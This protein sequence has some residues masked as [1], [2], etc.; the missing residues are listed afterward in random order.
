M[1]FLKTA[2]AKVTHPSISGA[3]WGQ[4]RRKAGDQSF[5]TRIAKVVSSEY[6]PDKYLLSH[7]TIVASVDVQDGPGALGRSLVGG[8]EI[9][10]KY[11][12]YLVTPETAQFVNNNGDCWSRQTLLN[13]YRTFIGGNNFVEHL[14]IPEMSKGTIV[15]AIA[16]D[17]GPSI[18]IDILVA[19]D[20]KHDQLVRAIQAGQVNAMSMGCFTAG[21]LV[22]MAD[23]RRVPIESITPGQQVLTHKGRPREVSALMVRTGE[24]GMRRLHVAGTNDPV[25]A[26]DTHVFFVVRPQRVCACGCGKDLPEGG[27]LTRRLKRRFIIGHQ[28]SVLNP[29]KK[30]SSSELSSAKTTLTDLKNLSV[31]EVRADELQVGDL[32][33]FPR[34]EGTSEVSIGQARLLGYFLAEGSFLKHNGSPTEVQFNF[35]MTEKDTYVSEVVALLRSEFPGCKPWVQDRTERTTC[36]VHVTGKDLVSWFHRMGGEY[37]HLKSMS[38]EVFTWGKEAWLHLLGTWLNGDGNRHVSGITE[39]TTTSFNL[40]SQMHTLALGCGL[41]ARI[42]CTFGGRRATYH[43]A[44]YAGVSKRHPKTGRLATF[45]LSFPK[46]SSQTLEGYT[47]KHPLAIVNSQ[48]IRSVANYEL[49]PITAIEPFSHE[50]SV[51]DLEVEED[52]SYLVQGMAVHNCTV[53]YTVCT[54]CGNVAADETQMCPHVKYMKR[55][56]FADPQGVNRIIAELCGHASDPES[57]KFIEASWVANPA[58]TGAVIRSVLSPEEAKMYENRIQV[59]FTAPRPVVDQGALQKA[60]R[61][62]LGFDFDLGQAT[63]Q[64]GQSGEA[65]ADAKPAESGEPDPVSDAVKKLETHVRNKVL[66]EINRKVDGTPAQTPSPAAGAD[67][68]VKQA[69]SPYWRGVARRIA[70]N[71]HNR[72]D[73]A[74]LLRGAMIQHDHGWQALRTANY[75]KREILA[76]SRLV[77]TLNQGTRAGDQSLYRTILAVGGT[78]DY[79][80]LTSYLTACRRVL[81]RELTKGEADTLVSKGRLYDLGV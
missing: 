42:R 11:Q 69:A 51:Y 56:F 7:A 59:A 54:Q 57:V 25:E 53:N 29:N 19:T 52:H 49:F 41:R 3:D 78:A 23:G 60:A 26:T 10:R 1:G 14:Q 43:E 20:R 71:V 18:Y 30:Y 40:A 76:V 61:Q 65:P 62:A 81:G 27:E 13:T 31:E 64:G 28:M 68:L 8:I 4:V 44:T 45:H 75:S 70:A 21:T 22:T 73:A 32:V 55:Q 15:D 77:D 16:R 2:K 63:G 33:V 67:T 9:D 50:G 46:G 72:G 12:D 80:D 35:S 39:G 6:S 36:V 34:L 58:F 37:S 66:D 48:T 74:R 24:W 47:D 5:G 17:I 79:P 38:P